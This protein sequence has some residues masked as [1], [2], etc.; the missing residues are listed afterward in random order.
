MTGNSIGPTGNGRRLNGLPVRMIGRPGIKVVEMAELSGMDHLGTGK[1][2]ED[3]AARYLKKRGYRILE[4]NYRCPYGEVDIVAQEGGAIVFVEVKSRRSD[5]FGDPQTAVGIQK[6][7]KLS[8]VSLHYLN[9]KDI[10]AGNARFDVVAVR[11]QAK[12]Y[13]VELIRDAF[14]LLL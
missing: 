2:G 4:R 7:K 5:D 6:Q 9:A 10:P 3:L 13:E 12:D 14:E 11:M 1:T 8:L